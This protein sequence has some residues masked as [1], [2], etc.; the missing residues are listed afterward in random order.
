MAWKSKLEFNP[1]MKLA[2]NTPVEGIFKG[3]RKVEKIDSL[4]HSIDIEGIT[5]DLYGCG[6]LDAQLKDVPTETRVKILYAGKKMATVQIGNKP[7]KKEVH[8]YV[9]YT[10][11]KE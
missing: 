7:T 3:S 8:N 1:I 2:P 11:E 6:S 4:L 5:Y 9:V 10:Q